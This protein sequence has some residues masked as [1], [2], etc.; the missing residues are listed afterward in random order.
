M[1][2]FTTPTAIRPARSLRSLLTLACTIMLGLTAC[3]DDDAPEAIKPTLPAPEGM[4]VRTISYVGAFTDCYDWTFSYNS[5]RMLNATS[6][7]HQAG[8]ESDNGLTTKFSLSYNN[9]GVSLKNTT[10][11]VSFPTQLNSLFHIEKMTEGEDVYTFNYTDGLLS[12]WR[13]K[14]VKTSSM[15]G[16]TTMETKGEITYDANGDLKKVVYTAEQGQQAI[17]L[18]TLSDKENICGLLPPFATKELGCAGFEYLYY[19]GLLGRPTAHLVERIEF[20]YPDDEEAGQ[21]VTLSYNM[22]GG[23]VQLCNFVTSNGQPGTVLYTY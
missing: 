14:V 3:S 18:F 16:T 4:N 10:K 6:V 15:G 2:K 12:S 5:G 9:K 20:V 13:K 17:V 21:T 11:G 22:K 23:K 19:A 8:S 7:L 1:S